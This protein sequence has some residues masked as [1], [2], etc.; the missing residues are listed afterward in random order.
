MKNL[1]VIKYLDY[2]LGL[3]HSPEYA[4]LLRGKWGSGK[5]WFIKEY[6][7][8]K[9]SEKFVYISLYGVSKF[10]EI[11]EIIFQQIHPVL[12]SKGMKLAGKV[13]KGA[14]KATIR[15][16]LDGD[17]KDDVNINSSIPDIKLPEYLKKLDNKVLVFDDLE[18]CTIEIKNILGYINQLV[19][20]NGQRV[21]IVANEEEIIQ[22]LNIEKKEE[23]TNEYLRTKEKLIGKSFDIQSETITAFDTFV[24]Y[25]SDKSTRDLLIKKKDLILSLYNASKYQNLR[26]LK[27]SIQDFGQFYSFLPKQT[28]KKD[29]LVEHVL[30][31]FF[32][33]SIEMK[34][35]EMKEDD[36]SKLFVLDLIISDSKNEK[37][38][39]SK[40]KRKYAILDHSYPPIR[41]EIWHSFF[42]YGQIEQ[43]IIENAIVNSYYFI[44]EN[45]PSWQKLWYYFDLE[46]D[47]FEDVAND[48]Y[49]KLSNS[50]YENQY[51]IIQVVGILLNLIKTKLVTY[52]KKVIIEEGKRN[53]NKIKEKG[54]LHLDTR[55]GALLHV[56]HNKQYQSLDDEEF[57]HFLNW[58]IEEAEKGE[59]D[60]YP[61]K[62]LKLIFVLQES[63]SLFGDEITHNNNKYSQYCKIPILKYMPA[64]DFIEV[65]LKL[66]NKNLKELAWIIERR[67]QFPEFRQKLKDEK[68]WLKEVYDKLGVIVREM[69]VKMSKGILNELILKQIDN[70]IN[71]LE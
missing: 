24:S 11:E 26:H 54:L 61:E 28:F 12:G 6:I 42:K 5:S 3:K 33:L 65:I 27:Q 49:E 15:F 39:R 43:T 14:L 59:V 13:L 66:S 50:E 30:Q 29:E 56:S 41:E 58:V 16:D 4:I 25:M 55:G 23:T 68:K 57:Q 10:S 37:S 36:I 52:S 47:K 46:D 31:L 19:E 20:N 22:Q 7:K 62:A 63:V 45:T 8:D 40:L 21:I 44:D 51:V 64:E 34:S 67:Y 53:I 1:H 60:S 2:Y 71:Q 70:A 38:L 35:G 9:G 32:I 48:V 69:P 17:K 18:R